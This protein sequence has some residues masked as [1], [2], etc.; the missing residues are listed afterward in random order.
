M[1]RFS[2][3]FVTFMV[4]FSVCYGQ[5]QEAGEK[6]HYKAPQFLYEEKCSKCHTLERV[7]AESKTESEWRACVTRMMQKNKLW[8]TEEDGMQ[9]ISEIV[10]KRKENI[11]SV[12]QKRTY[13]DT[14]LLFIDRCTKCHTISRILNKD[15]ARE[16]WVETVQR[17]R[18]NAPELFLDEDIPILIEYLVERG[19]MM[20]DDIAAQIMVEK[21]LVCHEL[22]R[23]LLER[24]SKKEWEKC[25]VDMRILA[26]QS[27]K[28]DWFTR[29]EFNLIVDLLVKTQG[30]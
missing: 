15:K 16:E 19:R 24:K 29:D 27:F 18:D 22:G 13:A 10:G 23:I 14:Q 9:I 26:K 17:M 1:L 5:A 12:S 11:V 7:F 8:I 21:C 3:L 28:K 25:V 20:R 4:S 6:F 2:I 30:S